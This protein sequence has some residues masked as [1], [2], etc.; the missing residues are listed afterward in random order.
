MLSPIPCISGSYLDWTTC[1]TLLIKDAMETFV[2]VA[3]S[4]AVDNGRG[5]FFWFSA[6]C[7]VGFPSF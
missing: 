2:A 6:R 7:C 4:I 5:Y 1:E 3:H